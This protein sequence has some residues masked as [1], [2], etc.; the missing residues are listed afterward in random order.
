MSHL[1]SQNR[2]VAAFADVATAPVL[3]VAAGVV[4]AVV[5]VVVVVAAAAPTTPSCALRFRPAFFEAASI[6][7]QEPLWLQ[8]STLKVGFWGA[9]ARHQRGR[10]T[11]RKAKTAS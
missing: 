1:A 10:M 5:V 3:A 8:F 4:D 11:E 6:P 2:A 7:F 9:L